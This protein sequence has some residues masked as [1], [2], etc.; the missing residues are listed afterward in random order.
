LRL[1]KK[2]PQRSKGKRKYWG[3]EN[4]GNPTS[5]G[6][7]TK[8]SGMGSAGCVKRAKGSAS[9]LTQCEG[10]LR[11]DDSSEYQTP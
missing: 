5:I 10:G 8:E 3:E 4:K 9:P 6:F 11:S 7:T 1:G 2:A